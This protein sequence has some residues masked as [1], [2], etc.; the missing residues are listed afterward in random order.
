MPPQSPEKPQDQL[1]SLSSVSRPSP[2]KHKP[3]GSGSS[4]REQQLSSPRKKQAKQPLHIR[5]NLTETQMDKITDAFTNKVTNSPVKARQRVDTT[6]SKATSQSPP[7]SS[8]HPTMNYAFSGSGEDGTDSGVASPTFSELMPRPQADIFAARA[9]PSLAAR[10][11]MPSPSPIQVSGR[12]VAGAVAF[13]PEQ[14]M[15]ESPLTPPGVEHHGYAQMRSESDQASGFH[16]SGRQQIPMDLRGT[17]TTDSSDGNVNGPV[18][19]MYNAWSAMRSTGDYSFQPPQ[20]VESLSH[21]PRRSKSTSEGLRSD[22]LYLSGTLSPL[23]PIPPLPGRVPTQSAVAPARDETLEDQV[24]SPLA[25]Y[26]CGRD[27]PTVKKGEKTMIGQNGWLE[28]TERRSPEKEKK[29]PQKKTGI[30][31]SIKKI[32]KDMTA[33]FSNPSRKTP[34]LAKD[35]GATSQIAISLNPREQSLLYCELEY[36]LT[37]AIHD[38]I[39]NEL[40]RGHLVAD[41]LKKIADFWVSQGR[42]KVI[43]FRYDLETQLELVHLHINDFNFYGRR[44][45]N[46]VEIAGLLH[47]MKVNARQIRVRTFCQPDSVIAKQLV[48]S[49]SLFNMINVS[50]ARQ[51]GLTEIA[52]FFKVIVEREKD[53]REQRSR[54]VRNTRVSRP[55]ETFA[56]APPSWPQHQ[57]ERQHQQHHQQHDRAGHS[58]Q[59]KPSRERDNRADDRTS[60]GARDVQGDWT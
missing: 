46:P 8:S 14:A 9:D 54:E 26:F 48:D 51:V 45:S 50:I 60:Y 29:T 49:Q 42:P 15:P 47:C 30:L 7:G 16:P 4:S 33:E 5:M 18:I 32:A 20:R 12:R 52:Q 13:N 36:H 58:H 38:Y 19:D 43:G 39:T 2:R 55:G 34:A 37:G 59:K 23:T 3:R 31:E 1:T 41:N 40:E 10:R 35:A 25:L 17:Y 24:F 6:P 27:F 53:V 21:R 28:R 56:G 57:Q 22:A 11:Q 44:Q